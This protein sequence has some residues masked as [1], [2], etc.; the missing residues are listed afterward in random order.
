MSAGPGALWVTQELRWGPWIH[1]AHGGF[2]CQMVTQGR[3]GPVFPEC[4]RRLRLAFRKSFLRD[5]ALGFCITSG[6]PSEIP[7]SLSG[8][9]FCGRFA[10]ILVNFGVIYG[11]WG[12]KGL[13]GS[14][15]ASKGPLGQI[16]QSL[17]GSH[18]G[19][20]MGSKA[21]PK[22]HQSNGSKITGLEMP[23][24]PPGRSPNS[25]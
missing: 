9:A 21:Q 14:K 10:W 18:F 25:S 5:I 20:E 24:Q 2:I 17:L 6:S 15:L 19:S 23:K 16:R 7:N 8:P 13:P 4:R 3:G 12:Q 11:S 22:K 1:R